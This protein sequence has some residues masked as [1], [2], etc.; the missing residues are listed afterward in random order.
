MAQTQT[1][2][3]DKKEVFHFVKAYVQI[4]QFRASIKGGDLDEKGNVDAK[5][6]QLLN[7]KFQKQAGQII[8]KE[9]LSF[10]SFSKY[11]QLLHSSKHFQKLVQS[12][13]DTFKS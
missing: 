1:I 12:I 8:T 10:E 4:E 13:I 7:E 2:D 6:A 11:I 9:G 3:L 5:K